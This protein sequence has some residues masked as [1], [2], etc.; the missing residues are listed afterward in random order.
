[1]GAG[2]FDNKS[3]KQAVAISVGS[4]DQTISPPARGIWVGGAG[5]LVVRL[6]NDANDTT[7]TG[8]T[9][10]TWLPI[11]VSIVRQTGTTVTNAVALQ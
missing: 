2:Q 7:F 10:G 9:A 1:M 8:V 6:L 11:M 4:G 5:N 3:A